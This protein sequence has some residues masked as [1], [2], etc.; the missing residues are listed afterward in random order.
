MFDVFRFLKKE[1]RVKIFIVI[2]YFII[3]F[4]FFLMVLS[5][6]EKKIALIEENYC[7]KVIQSDKYKLCRIDCENKLTLCESI[8]LSMQYNKLNMTKG[9]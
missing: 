6:R 1:I 8:I 3:L 7:Y 5:L 2:F 9:D 4:T